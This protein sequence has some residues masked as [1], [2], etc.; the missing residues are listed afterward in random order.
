MQT[1][2]LSEALR[3][4]GLG[5]IAPAPTDGLYQLDDLACKIL[6]VP[7]P[8]A[9]I[10]CETLLTY[11]HTDDRA[12]FEQTI[13]NRHPGE[14]EFKVQV[15]LGL[16][17][18]YVRAIRGQGQSSVIVLEDFTA[19]RQR[20]TDRSSMMERLSENSQLEALGTL[21]G[22][23]AHEINNPAQ[24][25]GDNLNFIRE[26]MIGLFDLAQ[27]AESASQ[28]VGAKECHQWSSVVQLIEK[29]PLALLI[30]EIPAATFQA[31]DGIERIG[32]I[33][34]AI[35]EFCYPSSKT[36]TPLSLNHLVEIATTVTRNKWKYAAT[37]DLNLEEGLP[38]IV[39]VEGELYQVLVNLIINAIHA[40]MERVP[41]DDGHLSISTAKD[42]AMIRLTVSD[43]GSGIPSESLG[44]IF[45][46]FYT[47]KPP[48]QGTGQG[49][50]ITHAIVSRHGGRISVE[51]ALGLG[52][53]F[54]IFLP[55]NG[56]LPLSGGE[57]G[58]G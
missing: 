9:P 31:I 25:I 42:G 22:G 55:I 36:P 29:L 14:C 12:H 38:I 8:N 24:F 10:P 35:R 26:A 54:H 20:E 52:S 16:E 17:L 43:N 11:I 53:S 30:K 34:Q 45:D 19:Y 27:A 6:G 13:L 33:V 51:T 7:F 21:A 41:S 50:A 37:L 15:P 56:P 32:N 23:I 40:I 4:K 5:C 18:R 48:G 49:L 46:M 44:R 28:A 1:K 47:T 2:F 58:A 3:V 39:A 57:Y